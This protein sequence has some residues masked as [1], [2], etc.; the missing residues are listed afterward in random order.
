MHNRAY[1]S[2]KAHEY[3][4]FR[5]A[6]GILSADGKNIIPQNFLKVTGLGPSDV[7]SRGNISRPQLYKKEI[8]IKVS[9]KFIKRVIDIVMVTDLAYELFGNNHEETKSWLMSPNSLLFGDSPFEVCMRGD[10]ERL[11]KWLLERLDRKPIE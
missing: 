3:G 10:A 11:K 9:T 6:L 8:P 1:H 4:K 7:A 5:N 2:S